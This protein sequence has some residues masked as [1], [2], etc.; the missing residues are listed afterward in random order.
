MLGFDEFYSGICL[1]NE[2]KAQK[3]LSQG[4]RRVLVYVLPT[5]TLIPH[6][7]THT[8]MAIS[9]NAHTHTHKHTHYKII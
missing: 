4:S 3:N 8:H 9:T 5:H 7:H 2:E 1:T 6:T